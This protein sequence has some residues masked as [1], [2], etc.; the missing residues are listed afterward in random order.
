MGRSELDLIATVSR[1]DPPSAH[2][3]EHRLAR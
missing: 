1:A 3:L 2:R